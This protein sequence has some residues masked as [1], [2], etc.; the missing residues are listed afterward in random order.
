MKKFLFLSFIF[1]LVSCENHSNSSDLIND[2]QSNNLNPDSSDQNEM[3]A[4]KSL[5]QVLEAKYDEAEL[6]CELSAQKDFSFMPRRGAWKKFSWDLLSNTQVLRTFTLNASVDPQQYSEINVTIDSVKIVDYVEHVGPEGSIY[7]LKYTPVI[8]LSYQLE[9]LF[10]YTPGVSTQ[11]RE[12]K[13]IIIY[14][15][16][17]N[18]PFFE[19][20]RVNDQNVFD[21][22]WY[23]IDFRCTLKTKIRPAYADHFRAQ[24]K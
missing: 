14:E 20:Q 2:Q 7:L 22:E 4:G 6:V 10:S 5:D 3:F 8:N 23:F 17:L 11:G 16:F 1:I 13:K 21:P 19:S 12:Q 15:K 18:N 9:Y 24:G